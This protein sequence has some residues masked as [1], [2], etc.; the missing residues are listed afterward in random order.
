MN[1][2][3]QKLDKIVLDP[4][5]HDV[6]E[7]VKGVRNGAVYGGKVRLCHALV[8]TILF[9]HGR[10]Q[11]KA[12]FVLK[13]TKEHA[14]NLASYVAI[15]KTTLYMLKKRNGKSSDIDTL[16]AGLLGGYVIFG[17][18]GGSAINQQIVLYVF[19]RVVL[20]LSKLSLKKSLIT[21]KDKAHADKVWSI[22]ASVCWGLVMYMFRTDPDCLQPSLKSSMDY[23]YM[24]SNSWSGLRTLLWHNK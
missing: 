17:R 19:S 15:Y 3:L 11:D 21:F 5:Y 9:R 13:A 7:I 8:M 2:T 20:G 6:L 10:I 16:L 22:F 18:G 1:S 14:M 12:K 24:D 4:R 23:L